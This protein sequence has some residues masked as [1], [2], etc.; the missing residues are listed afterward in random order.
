[1]TRALELLA[2][3]GVAALLSVSITDRPAEVRCASAFPNSCG[4]VLR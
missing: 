4:S 1:M 3:L 2:V